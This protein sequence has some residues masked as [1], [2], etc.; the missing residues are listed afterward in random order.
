MSATTVP[1]VRLG[2]ADRLRSLARGR[3]EDP[4]WV[5]PGIAAALL[6][7]ALLCLW[8]LTAS[9]YSNTYYAAAAKAGSESWKAWFF[10]S[11]DP[12][13]FITVDKPPLSLWLMG[14]SAR[15]LGF[16][17]F[18]LLLPQALCT[19]AA[20]ALLYATVRRVFSPAAGVLAAAAL[21]I[22]PVTVAIARVDNPDA[23]LVLLL[24]ASAW[25]TVRAVES[26]RTRHL[27][28]AGAMVGLAFM[29]K[30]L[31]GW[32]V[33][34]A[35]AAAYAIA[36]PGP[37]LRRAWQLA[38]AGVATLA[39]SAAWPLAVSL[40]PGSTPYIGGSEDGSVWNLILGY[41]GLGRIFG[42][43]GG[44]GGGGM[45]FGGAAGLWR[46]FNAQVGG[47]IA[48]LLPLAGAGLLA[49]LWLTRRAPRTSLARAG[50]VL[51]G[52]W[53]LVHV[54]VFSF[55]QGIFHPYY[56]S[57]LAPAVAALSGGGL[58]AMWAW[59]R[60]S[61][62][63]TAALSAAVALTAYVAL[64]VL[65][66][67][68][69]FA[70]WLRYAVYAGAVLAVIG[71]AM[72]RQGLLGR[73]AIAAVAVALAIATA[74]GPAAYSVATAGRALDGNNVTA[75][76]ASASGFGGPGGGGGMGGQ[77]A[78]S[79]ET[80][81]WLQAHQGSAK[82]LVAATGSQTTAGIIIASGEPVVTIGGFNGGDP[83]PTVAQL[84]AMVKAGELKYVLVGGGMGGGPG[85]ARP[86]PSCRRGCRSTAP[87]SPTPA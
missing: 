14:L 7:A 79:T 71:L 36:G 62:A 17:S 42:E 81:A 21:A 55:Q 27:A 56:A 66:R 64:V 29:T 20:V 85:A 5:R 24:V 52:V 46:M 35:L 63:G 87:P 47:Q 84:E 61:W 68:P 6:L 38:V 48:W 82:Y 3:P 28:L 1:P 50:W 67:T 80:I 41:N 58:V 4:A 25:F 32:M 74:A 9:G 40:W 83:A 34:P 18:S 8:D 65:G 19:I 86:P 54:A 49:G 51:F 39:V 26:G 15:V 16:S 78:V 73:R 69:D 43:G 22:T 33:L 23:L 30:M 11:L 10:G 76:P 53:A 72:R 77:G 44:M 59:A 70:P 75:G 13:S 37:L 12:G 57:A 45:G 2:A 31:Q 60:G